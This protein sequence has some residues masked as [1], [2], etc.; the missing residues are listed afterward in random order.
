MSKPPES[1]K[2]GSLSARLE[3][4]TSLRGSIN[5][6]S[7][8]V[9]EQ[10]QP[11]LGIWPICDAGNLIRKNSI[12]SESDCLGS[13]IMK[14]MLVEIYNRSKGCIEVLPRVNKPLLSYEK[15]RM[16]T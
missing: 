4:D 6:V 15:H 13:L 1:E 2:I 14:K 3:L 11:T 16:R 7:L 8:V 5:M 12:Q 10:R 9:V